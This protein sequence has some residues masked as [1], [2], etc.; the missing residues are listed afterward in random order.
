MEFHSYTRTQ[1]YVVSYKL[2]DIGERAKIKDLFSA[3]RYEAC[4]K[5][6]T[7]LLQHAKAQNLSHDEIVI[8]LDQRAACW[9]KS[10]LLTHA[11]K[12]AVEMVKAAPSSSRG[13]L[14]LGKLYQLQD[15]HEAARKAYSVG[16]KRVPRSDGAWDLLKQLY[17]NSKK[18]EAYQRKRADPLRVL[19][20]EILDVVFR[21]LPL[22]SLVRCL[23]VS[24]SWRSFIH[25]NARL[26]S[27]RILLSVDRATTPKVLEW[28]LR[29]AAGNDRTGSIGTVQLEKI[30]RGRELACLSLIAKY[31]RC[32]NGVRIN[33]GRS[34]DL[35]RFNQALI[36]DRPSFEGIRSFAITTNATVRCAIA[37]CQRNKSIKELVWDHRF[38]TGGDEPDLRILQTPVD[39][40]AT[41]LQ[42]I[43]IS[44]RRG[45]PEGLDDRGSQLS[46]PRN[47]LNWTS[48]LIDLSTNLVEL[49]LRGSFPNFDFYEN[50]RGLLTKLARLEVLRLEGISST[51]TPVTVPP[52]VSSTL[53]ILELTYLSLIETGDR[54]TFHNLPKL[55]ALRLH[56]CSIDSRTRTAHLR[57]ASPDL[58]ELSLKQ[59]SICNQIQ[60]SDIYVQ[61]IGQKF[62]KL[63]ILRIIGAIEVSDKIIDG[64]LQTNTALELVDLKGTK[65][66]GTGYARLVQGGITKLGLDKMDLSLETLQWLEQRSIEIIE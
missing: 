8:L 29:L 64:I 48:Q 51:R 20:F 3:K 10:E 49:C 60:T 15:N 2:M 4:C 37:L 65:V 16:L 57:F 14:R 66:S 21:N 38:E 5:L 53:R 52:L 11:V 18:S 47:T 7:K 6:L 12:D 30:A 50:L 17:T 40:T 56:S 35:Y 59:S 33:L 23:L 9:E 42:S 36:Q 39:N 63:R 28:Y 41:G 44:S 58:G 32:I 22:D 43:S 31:R 25:E 61:S 19:P 46:I 13:Y 45:T 55:E 1:R 34:L 54:L 24:R 62:P 27:D 26:W